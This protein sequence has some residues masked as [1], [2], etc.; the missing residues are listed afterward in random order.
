MRRALQV[1]FCAVLTLVLIA[2][3]GSGSNKES[4]AT[5]P[6]SQSQS[7][8]SAAV[9]SPVTKE[10]FKIAT[11]VKISGIAWYTRLEEGLKRYAAETGDDS[12]MVGP[13]QADAAQQQKI[14]EDLIAQK[15]DAI[16]VV[17]LSP[18]SLEPV[19]K[20]ARDQGIVVIS[21]EAGGMQNVDYDLEAF[22]NKAYGEHF[23]DQLAKGMGEQ[24]EYAVMVGSLT[25]KSHNEFVDAA[26]AIQKEKYPNMKLAADKIETNEDQKT[27]YERTK[28][29]M[30]AHPNIKGIEGSA[31]T[32]V[33][34][35]AL[36]LEEMGLTGK[37][38]VVGTSLVSVAG[39][40]LEAGS[41]SSISF[42]DP[43]S[44][45]YVTNKL[46]RS[47]LEG[48]TITDGMDLGEKG[49]NKVSLKGNVIQGQAWI[50]V[51]KEN[52]ADYPF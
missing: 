32:D 17:P 25:A 49:Y 35:I 30:K 41:A 44:V 50:D 11:V 38:T 10:N 31:M 43:A 46:A 21:H 24:G 28:E 18:E 40:Y 14:I 15:V 12:F 26:I 13:P 9:S 33:P 29:L 1:M 23:M 5:N 37:V 16:V 45:G 52:M 6:A 7:N 51:T 42:W 34:G 2:G 19:L 36:A 20:R 3:C 48:K 8:E 22:E 27:A 4:Q 39:Q 47:I